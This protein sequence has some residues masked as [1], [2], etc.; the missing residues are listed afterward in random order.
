MVSKN[1]HRKPFMIKSPADLL[2]S[3]TTTQQASFSNTRDYGLEGT[4]GM[5]GG[6]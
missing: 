5:S 6:G 1:S 4:P 2:K 3:H